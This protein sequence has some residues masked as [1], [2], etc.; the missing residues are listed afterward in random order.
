[1][2]SVTRGGRGRRLNA[3]SSSSTIPA[4]SW[5]A[6]EDAAA[7]SVWGGLAERLKDWDCPRSTGVLA[8]LASAR[9]FFSSAM[10]SVR[11]RWEQGTAAHRGERER[12]QRRVLGV[13]RCMGGL[14]VYPILRPVPA[15]TQAAVVVN[16][17]RLV[18]RV[19]L[20]PLPATVFADLL[21]ASGAGQKG[22]EVLAGSQE[23]VPCG[24]ATGGR[25]DSRAAVDCE[26]DDG[27][28]W[29]GGASEMHG[30]CCGGV[31][32]VLCA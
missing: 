26:R 15:L 11:G 22:V 30:M 13:D 12:A 28:G 3:V 6:D 20:N 16:L 29:K 4:L 18:L 31:M 5:P 7:S 32:E 10:Q 9:R 2:T 23:L 21:V 1:M 27:G 8:S 24:G 19:L 17:P 25:H 14:T